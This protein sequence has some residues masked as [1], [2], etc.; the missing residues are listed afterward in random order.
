MELTVR[1]ALDEKLAY[2]F[3]HPE[4]LEEALRHS[5]LVNEQLDPHLRD[6]ERMEF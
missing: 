1:Q 4:Y 2:Q 3:R 5:S 6:N